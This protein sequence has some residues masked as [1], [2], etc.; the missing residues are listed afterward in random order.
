MKHRKELI[1]RYI[2]LIT[3]LVIM[4]FGIAFSIKA[5][6][7]TSPVSSIPYVLSLFLP[8]SV[9]VLSIIFNC[10]LVLMQIIILRKNFDP[11]QLMQ[12]PVA[13]L[14]GYLTDFASWCISAV[15][16]PSYLHQCI[17]CFI[18]IILVAFGVAC[19][20]TANVVTLAGE[21]LV[22]AICR[23]TNMKFGN[24]KVIFDTTMVLTSAA[25]SLVMSGQLQGVR[26]GTFVAAIAV[27]LMAKFFIKRLKP[28]DEKFLSCANPN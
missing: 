27:G 16:V 10:A 2:F 8:V 11:I 19:Q 20:V 14:F 22:L 7:G 6:L 24:M 23:V 28:I 12:I 4:T 15:A 18:G 17:Y 3:G 5:A 21:G 9:G 13:I 1:K 25:V 26:E